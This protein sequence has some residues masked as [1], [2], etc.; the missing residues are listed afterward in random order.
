MFS[1]YSASSSYGVRYAEP[2][3]TCQQFPRKASN[4]ALT[5][6]VQNLMKRARV[7]PW[8][9]MAS[10]QALSY[11]AK[12]FPLLREHGGAQT[13]PPQRLV[14]HRE[15]EGGAAS[16]G[17]RQKAAEHMNALLLGQCQPSSSDGLCILVH[18]R[19]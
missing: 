14:H 17:G 12:H 1:A 6:G 10:G 11:P 16:A 4:T 15:C 8:G 9:S 7:P 3:S 18:L 5:S 2:K 13:Q 19:S